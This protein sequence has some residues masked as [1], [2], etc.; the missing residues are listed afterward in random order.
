MDIFRCDGCK[1]EEK[2]NK[3]I[4]IGRR[5]FLSVADFKFEYFFPHDQANSGSGLC[6]IMVLK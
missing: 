3:K 2:E 4:Q 1:A 6:S 5:S